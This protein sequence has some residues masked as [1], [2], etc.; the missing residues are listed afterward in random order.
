MD[1]K[2]VSKFP[3]R[4]NS[5]LTTEHFTLQGARAIVNSEIA[6]RVTIYFTTLSSVIIAAAFVAQIPEMNQI[7]I[8]FAALAFPLV[9]LLG[10][11]TAARLGV[12][13]SMDAAYIR[14]INR[15]RH[16]YIESASEVEQ[17]LLFP[18]FD[19]DRSVGIYGGWSTASLRDNLLS[20][21]NAVVISNCIVTTVLIGAVSTTYYQISFLQFLPI[22]IILFLVAYL[23]HG[24][25]AYLFSRP[26]LREGAYFETRFPST[27]SQGKAEDEIDNPQ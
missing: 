15:I 21:A 25:V 13:A 23:L 17:F 9:I 27:A 10:F 8:L 5:Y 1:P 19:D 18:P 24:G 11:F 22:G 6:S 7:F 2:P 20:S 16:Y 4:M 12:L 14:A 26:L 3:D